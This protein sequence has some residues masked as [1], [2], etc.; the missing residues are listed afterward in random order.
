MPSL[1]KAAAGVTPQ[2]VSPTTIEPV[3]DTY[4]AGLFSE[5]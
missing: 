1:K 2:I 4:S 5:A 3:N